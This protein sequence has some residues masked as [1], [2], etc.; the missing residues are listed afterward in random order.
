LGYLAQHKLHLKGVLLTHHHHDHLDG[1]AELQKV[2]N[3]P[4]YG[5][6]SQRIPQVTK[7]LYDGDQLQLG[8]LTANIISLPG[9]TLDHIAYLI[10]TADKPP[11][12]FSGDTL[13]AVGCG[14]LFDGTAQLLYQALQKIANLPDN[15]LIYG[16]HEYTLANIR[17]AL[18]IEPDNNDL[19]VRQVSETHKRELGIPTLPTQLA[20]EKRTNPFLRCHLKSVRTTVERLSGETFTSDADVF[21]RLR[22]IKDSF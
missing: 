16:G 8:A 10:E 13:F 4:I 9:H 1:A 19:Q 12:L 3:I 11:L 17:F 5:P 22:L 2:Y 6:N 18:T 14:R 15:T 21:A 7:H 20:L